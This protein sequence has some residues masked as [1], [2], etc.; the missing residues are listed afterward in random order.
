MQLPSE[1]I[2]MLTDLLGQTNGNRVV[3]ALTSEPSP[4]SIRLNPF[5]AEAWKPSSPMGEV[6]WNHLG[7]YL[8][9]RPNFTFDPLFHAGCYY[10]Q[11]ASSM[12]IG[13]V[14][15]QLFSD[16]VIMLDLCAAPGGKS[17]CAMSSLPAG[18]VLFSNE[19]I[20]QRAS[21]LNENILKFG[22]PDIL[23]TSNYARDYAHSGL[24]FDVILTDV[25]CSGEGMMR[26]EP[27][28][29]NQWST[30]LV[31]QCASLQRSIVEDIWP[32]LRPGGLLVYSTCTFNRHEDE[33][34]ASWIASE[35]GAE[36]IEISTEDGWG[37]KTGLLDNVPA[38]RFLPG[39]VSGEGL[40]MAVLRKHGESAAATLS[41]KKLKKSGLHI[42]SHGI[43]PDIQK[44]RKTIPD[45]SKA[46]STKGSK[47]PQV[48][49]NY[50]T[51]LQYLRHE[52]IC[53]PPEAPRGYVE[54]AFGGFPLGFANNLGN[55][56]NNLYPP[57]WRIRSTHT[58]EE[59]SPV[60]IKE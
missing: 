5:K 6:P 15:R 60:I 43:A 59:Y 31:D 37:I 2:S 23:V 1:F 38:L 29:V 44:G 20:P 30:H 47:Q 42:L 46:L 18:S 16:P 55:R 36:F 41:D 14:L 49:V 17:T 58:P 22:H 3:E 45:I 35:L 48:D 19:P 50:I 34:N 10:V 56:A 7:W 25:P 53:L 52:A 26:K 32:C 33:D 40:F 12:F 54:V 27:E 11:E 4:V 9:E 24:Q 8:P 39:L 57:E 28:A 21:V 13:E 51:A